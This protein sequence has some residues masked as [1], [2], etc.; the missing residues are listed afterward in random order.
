M[1]DKVNEG[2]PER[3]KLL[4]TVLGYD[5]QT[6]MVAFLGIE[7]NRYNNIRLGSP[8][9]SEVAIRICQK[10]PGM[11][12]DWLYFGKPD[13][14]PLDL[15]RRLGEAPPAS[16]GASTSTKRGVRGRAG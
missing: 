9:S 11:T 13:G 15:A 5:T 6:G 10:V 2:V 7:Y 16:G 8:L 4:E 12:L 1:Q 14:L 3:L